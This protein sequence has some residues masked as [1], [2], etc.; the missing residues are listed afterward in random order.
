IYY[1]TQVSTR[2]PTF[3][4]FVNKSELY[5]FSYQR[6]IENQIRE[7]FGLKG[8]PMRFITRER[9]EEPKIK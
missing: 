7:S 2:P 1:M 6:Y 5:H 3:I 4:S 9:D 8:T